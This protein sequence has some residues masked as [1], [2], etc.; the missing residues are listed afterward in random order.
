MRIL[1]LSLSV[2]V[3]GLLSSCATDAKGVSCGALEVLTTSDDEQYCPDEAAPQACEDFIVLLLDR[4]ADCSGLDRDL[5]EEE[6]EAPFDCNDAAATSTTYEDCMSDLEAAEC[7][8]TVP[9]FPDSCN[10]AVLTVN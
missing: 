3:A 10:G 4:S 8:G 7:D 5:L 6:F 1:L 2:V 9:T